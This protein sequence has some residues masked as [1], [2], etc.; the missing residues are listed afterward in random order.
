VNFK[1]M[2]KQLG[3]IER[4]IFTFQMVTH[5][6]RSMAFPVEPGKPRGQTC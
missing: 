2:V 4:K 6:I 3:G 1:A 5:K